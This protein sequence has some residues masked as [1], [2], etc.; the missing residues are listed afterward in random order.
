MV[1]HIHPH[2]SKQNTRDNDH[3][4]M[5]LNGTGRID[6]RVLDYLDDKLQSLADFETLDSLLDS[7]KSQQVLLK[8]QVSQLFPSP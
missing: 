1:C 6:A 2:V 7:V 8:Q 5:A 3:I 4:V